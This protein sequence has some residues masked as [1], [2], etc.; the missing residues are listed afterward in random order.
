MIFQKTPQRLHA[1]LLFIQRQS[2]LI[3]LDAYTM[4]PIALI[5]DT[6]FPKR[7]QGGLRSYVIS[8]RSWVIILGY[9]VKGKR[10]VYVLETLA[11]FLD[12]YFDPLELRSRE[13]KKDYI[14]GFFDAEGGIPKAKEDRFYIQL[15]QS[16]KEKLSKIKDLL[17]HLGIETGKIHNPSKKVDPHYWRIY[18]LSAS[19]KRFV[20]EIGSWHPRKIRTLEKRM[21]I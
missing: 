3:S 20:K 16:D 8:L 10:E 2:R 9:I 7:E 1:E 19:Q 15:T 17:V 14:R 21:V 4:G 6:G 11:K 18:V 5:K 12:I 13:E